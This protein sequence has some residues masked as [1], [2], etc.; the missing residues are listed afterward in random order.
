MRIRDITWLAGLVEAD[1]TIGLRRDHTGGL[2]RTPVIK[3]CMAD[4]DVIQRAAFLF[5]DKHVGE[6]KRKTSTGKKMYEV[7]IVASQ[8][9]AWIMTLFSE[10]GLRRRAQAVRAVSAWR[11]RPNRGKGEHRG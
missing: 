2:F 1:G 9:A 10:L 4:R 7:V 8:A 5:G 3:V 11:T 6:W